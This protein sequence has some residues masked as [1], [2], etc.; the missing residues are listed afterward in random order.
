MVVFGP[1]IKHLIE[2]NTAGR[3]HPKRRELCSLSLKFR[4]VKK[5]AQYM[6]FISCFLEKFFD[7]MHI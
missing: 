4:C 6:V 5:T 7:I 2:K 3:C 1:T